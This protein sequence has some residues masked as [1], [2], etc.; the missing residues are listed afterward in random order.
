MK[1]EPVKAMNEPPKRQA[2]SWRESVEWGRKAI[3]VCSSILAIWVLAV[4]E[5]T[6]SLGLVAA[7]LFVIGVDLARLRAKRWAL[8]M[9]R[10]FPLIFRRDERQTLSGASVMMAGAA[11]ASYLFPAGPAA[12]G[13]L[14]LAWGDSAAAVVGQAVSFQRQQ[15]GL[16]AAARTSAPVVAKRGN[17][18]WVGTF[19]CFAASALMIALVLRGHPY[20]VVLGGVA[21]AAM[22]RW[23][24]GRWDNLAIPLVTAGVV[25]IC[26]TWLAG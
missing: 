16:E 4:D 7:T 17:K 3:H 2:R 21:A 20:A 1:A 6:A 12:A 23:T 13:I 24:P 18:T 8:W 5:P 26:L 9:Y 19:A 25:Q 10:S 15:L 14:C 11:I 22:E